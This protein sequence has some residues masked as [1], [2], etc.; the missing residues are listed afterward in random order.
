[1]VSR[2]RNEIQ[3]NS[4]LPILR[5]LTPDQV[6]DSTLKLSPELSQIILQVIFR[7]NF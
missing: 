4:I 1:M 7:V 2:A 6:P 5:D 3:Y